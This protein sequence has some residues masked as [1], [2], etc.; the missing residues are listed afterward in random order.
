[1]STAIVLSNSKKAHAEFMKSVRAD[2]PP[3]YGLTV[4]KPS[5]ITPGEA[6]VVDCFCSEFLTLNMLLKRVPRDE[7]CVLYVLQSSWNLQAHE[8]APFS[9]V[10][11]KE[12]TQTMKEF[13]DSIR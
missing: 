7:P 2:F 4:V 1:M 3:P 12:D 9:M 10:I 11:V 13:V 5:E 8:K 6:K